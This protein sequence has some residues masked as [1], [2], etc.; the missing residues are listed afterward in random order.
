MP[1]L[2]ERALTHADLEIRSDGRTVYGLAVP[3]DRE[4]VVDDGHGQY[5]E[6][7]RHGAFRQSINVGIERVKFFVNHNHRD[8]KLPIG[9]AVNLREDR[10]G[11]VGEFRVSNTRDGDEAIE[12]VR[13]GVLDSFSIGFAEIAG[14][15]RKTRDLVERL[16]VKLREVSLVAFPAYAGALVG[17]LRAELTDD[18]YERLVA[19]ARSL[20]TQT[21]GAA[22]GTPVVEQLVTEVEQ[23]VGHSPR[24]RAQ[25]MGAALIQGALNG[26]P[27]HGDPRTTG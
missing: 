7:F 4:T 27:P 1:D 11:L 13:D 19:L 5:R 10:S 25:R 6:V 21:D 18:E 23:V 20:S 12:L 26:K 9:R 3:F 16:E 8:R 15:D 17:G 2:I 24:T 22:A 14:K